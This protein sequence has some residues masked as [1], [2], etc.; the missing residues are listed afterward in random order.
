MAQVSIWLERTLLTNFRQISMS[1]KCVVV[2][3]IRCVPILGVGDLFLRFYNGQVYI[4]T[5]IN[6]V[7]FVPDLKVNLFFV[8]SITKKGY[9]V[10]LGEECLVYK[11]F[12]VTRYGDTRVL[13]LCYELQIL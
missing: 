7:M 9:Q 10:I 1:N 3:Y 6:E 2:G 12:G 8:S 13:F 5:T 4:N 11:K